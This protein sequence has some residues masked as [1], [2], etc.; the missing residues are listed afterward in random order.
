MYDA[1]IKRTH[2]GARGSA[3]VGALCYKP[4]CRGFSSE[5]IGFVSKTSTTGNS[6]A[7]GSTHHLTE[8]SARNRPGGK[9]RPSC[10]T[11]N[12]TAISLSS[13]IMF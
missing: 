13:V 12:L 1:S 5:A 6:M 10:K 9:G 8:V 3:V 2:K 4:A 11:N 7:L